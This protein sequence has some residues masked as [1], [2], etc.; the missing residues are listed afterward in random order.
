M[1]RMTRRAVLGGLGVTILAPS[2]PQ[3]AATQWIDATRMDETREIARGIEQ[4]HSLTVAVKGE[5]PIAEAFR[6]PGLAAPVNVK[7]VSKTLL[8]TLVLIAID[9]GI[10]SGTRQRVL[11]LL[12]PLAPR[13]MSPQVAD[14]T[15]DHLMS[16]RSGLVRTSGAAYGD[17][18]AS[19]DWIGYILSQPVVARP[20]TRM[21]YSTGDYHILS[22]ALTR[23][24]GRSTY[25]LAAEWLG[26]PL[27]VVL[28]PWTRDP[29][30]IFM[31][32]NNMNMSPE[33]MVRFGEMA[34]SGGHYAGTQVVSKEMLLAAWTP[35]ARSPFSGHQYGYGWF[36]T[37]MAG[38]RVYYARGYGGQMIYVVPQL[39]TVIAVTS[40]PTL[41]ARYSGHGG[42]LNRL[43]SEHILPA[44]GRA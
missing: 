44:I 9:K 18:V 30:G 4:L 7:S 3:Q 15:L 17:W 23:A 21:S 12:G 19:D 32:G 11:P 13:R 41:P 28:P 2:M 5:R 16:M 40:D 43:V 1:A 20:G 25:E 6:G 22:A 37:L 38:R 33:G 26:D 29:N 42:V 27:G 39:D 34:L 8:S 31:G 36:Q 10:L 14:I 24:T 35:R